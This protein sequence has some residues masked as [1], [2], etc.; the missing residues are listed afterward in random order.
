MRRSVTARLRLHPRSPRQDR[1]TGRA[2]VSSHRSGHRLHAEN[3]GP[4]T[5]KISISLRLTF[6]FSTL[7]LCVFMVLGAAMWFDLAY[8]LSTGRDRTLSRRAR[9]LIDLLDSARGDSPERRAIKFDE[10]ADA[11]PEGNLI[12]VFDANNK[13]IYPRTPALLD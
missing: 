13:R 11:S 12:Q 7:V 4:L 1:A 5:R 3:R 10:F 6:W 9:R 8:S 2:P